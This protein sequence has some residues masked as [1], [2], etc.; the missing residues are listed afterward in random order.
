MVGL[1]DNSGAIVLLKNTLYVVDQ[2]NN[3]VVE[4]D[5]LFEG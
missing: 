5:M 4:K 3:I 2:A 1:E